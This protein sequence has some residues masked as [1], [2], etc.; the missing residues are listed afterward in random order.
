MMDEQRRWR[1]EVELAIK[2]IVDVAE[3]R[4][5]ENALTRC[6]ALFRL[7]LKT[8]P[9]Q[10]PLAIRTRNEKLRGRIEYEMF[11]L[12]EDLSMVINLELREIVYPLP[13]IKENTHRFG[14][15]FTPSKYLTWM[16]EDRPLSPEE[17]ISYLE[18]QL[19]NLDFGL[20]LFRK[21]RTGKAFSRYA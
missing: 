5:D 2:K 8:T 19:D 7:L 20:E 13:E 10:R 18:R 14:V 17:A 21:H 12:A 11:R 6:R 4:K 9:A 15:L 3:Q 16:P 1:E